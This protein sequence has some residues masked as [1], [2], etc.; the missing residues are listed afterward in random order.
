MNVKIRS[1]RHLLTSSAWPL[2]LP[3]MIAAT[4]NSAFSQTTQAK[5]ARFDEIVVTARKRE[6]RLIDVPQTIQVISALEIEQAGIKNLD[7]LG[8]QTPNLILNTRTD[9]EPNVVIRGVGGF[10]NTQGVGFFFDD[11]QNFTDASARMSDV[12][13]IEVLKGPQG[14]LYGGSNV[15]GAVKYILKR[16]TTDRL[17]VEGSLSYGSWDTVELSGAINI[18]VSD[19]LA[20]R[21]SGYFDDTDMFMTNGFTGNPLWARTEFGGRLAVQWDPTPDFSAYLSY[22]YG[23]LDGPY[24]AQV[25][26]DNVRNGFNPD[27]GFTYEPGYTFEPEGKRDTHSA[28]LHLRQSFSGVD[29]VSISSHTE[30]DRE[31]ITDIDFSPLDF[32]TARADWTTKFTSQELRAQSN[33]D[34]PLQW[35]VGGYFARLENRSLNNTDITLGVDAGGPFVIPNAIKADTVENT[36][37]GFA[38]L[39]YSFGRLEVSVGGRISR[40]EVDATFVDNFTEQ[41][42]DTNF[43]PKLTVSYN[44]ADDLMAYASAARGFEPGRI[45]PGISG[46]SRAPFDT[47]KATNYEAGLKGA[48]DEGRLVFELAAFYVDYKDRQFETRRL[49]GDP[50]LVT[51]AIFNIGSS[52]SYGFE[53]AATYW[54]TPEL[55]LQGGMGYLH[56][57]WTDGEFNLMPTDGLTV[58]NSPHFMANGSVNWNRAIG[59]SYIVRL[60]ADAFY[61]GS[62]Y[63]DIPNLGR[64]D[65]HILVGARIGFG[66]F[67]DRWELSVR[68]DNLFDEK[69][70][71]Q[72]GYGTL[73]APDANGNCMGC[74]TGVHGEPRSVTGTLRFSF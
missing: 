8:H 59:N 32:T 74:H 22:R 16:P 18:P 58:P 7:D 15:G 30:S 73:G 51:E 47:E 28:T 63:W 17:S 31:A 10:G 55:T 60:R 40:N 23:E 62:Q 4:P 52:E 41:N 66:D 42:N 13:R 67:D 12:E 64:A 24:N 36:Y 61:M 65:P 26:V 72:A 49:I 44:L 39:S 6:E 27:R 29:L 25:P 54:V 50:P 20:V 33:A 9:N 69:Y 48:L 5:E 56:A 45:N 70:V 38:D 35:T 1:L 19:T 37:A 3:L 34:S 46:G 68:V 2:C 53:A 43:V 57:R 11:V 71:T 21:V 14:T